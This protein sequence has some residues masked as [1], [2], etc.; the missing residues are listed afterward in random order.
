[1]E[2]E[3]Y[4]VRNQSGQ[5]PLNFP[6]KLNNRLASLM[7]V[8]TRGDTRPTGNAAPI[9]NDLK[10]ELKVQTDQLQQVLDDRSANLNA[11]QAHG[12][13][14]GQRKMNMVML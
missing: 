7:G 5:D 1:M 8:V 14:A 3:I 4:Q 6:I 9:F 12:T 2:E 10:A 13:G 11:A